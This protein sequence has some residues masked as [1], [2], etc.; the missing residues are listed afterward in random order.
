LSITAS[1]RIMK[2]FMPAAVSMAAVLITDPL[3]V[4]GRAR[5]GAA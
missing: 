4:G 2:A 1:C 3:A 5:G